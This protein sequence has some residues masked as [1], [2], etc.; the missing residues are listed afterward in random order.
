VLSASGV[1]TT[2][3]LQITP[4]SIVAGLT[5][6]MIATVAAPARSTTPPTGTVTFYDNGSD[7]NGSYVFY[8]VLVAGP[9]GTATAELVRLPASRFFNSGVNHMTALYSGDSIYSPS[10]SSTV[11]LTATQP[12]GD[13][14]LEASQTAITLAA[15]ASSSVALNL[16]ALVGF[17]GTVNLACTPST[18]AALCNISPASVALTNSGTATLSFNAYTAKLERRPLDRTTL[19]A[20]AACFVLLWPRRRR[21]HRL[22][23][24]VAAMVAA[25]GAGGC[26]RGGTP[27]AGAAGS[28]NQPTSAG[29]YSIGVTATSGTLTHRLTILVTVQ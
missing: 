9:N 26:G 29:S 5:A 19:A 17:T 21:R 12:G 15:G 24:C 1:P 3:S 22:I 8:G 23:V 6:T 4:T 20:L 10:T 11:D 7:G 13:F 25:M 2:T 16:T 14:K 27:P 18:A 28:S